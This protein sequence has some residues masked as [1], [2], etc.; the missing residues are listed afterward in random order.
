M[1]G[2]EISKNRLV[3]TIG[4]E[5]ISY[6]KDAVAI[7]FA[8]GE[9]K[10]DVIK[11]ALEHN[12]SNVYPAT[13]LNRLKNARFYLTKGAA[14]KLNDTINN[15]YQKGG[16]TQEKSERAIIE[17]CKKLDKRNFRKKI[18]K[19]DI[20]TQLDEIQKDVSHSAARLFQFNQDR[21]LELK[22]SGFI[23]EL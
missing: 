17:L 23:F 7:I 9:A 20:L 6:N 1:G 2:I 18:L 8:A 19:M 16:W 21:Y 22:K 11:N 15:Y 10:A 12:A 5:T 14:G 3:I 4:L 13:V